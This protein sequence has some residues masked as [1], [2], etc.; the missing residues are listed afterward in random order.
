MLKIILIVLCIAAIG[1]G[2]YGIYHSHTLTVKNDAEMEKYR[3]GKISFDKN[4]GKTLV[5][6][7]S[8]SGNTKKLAELIKEK[9]KADIYEIE[10]DGN[11]YGGFLKTLIADYKQIKTKEYPKIKNELPDLSSYD[12]I[13]VGSPVW[14]YTVAPPVLS[15]LQSADLSGKTVV[16]F[17]SYGGN[18]GT[19]FEDFAANAKNAQTLKGFAVFNVLKESQDALENKVSDFLNN[20]EAKN[21]ALVSLDGNPTTGYSWEYRQSKDGVVRE[22]S[23]KYEPQKTSLA[24]SG[25][26]FTFVFEGISQ[27]ETELTFEYLRPWEKNVKPA[28]T[29]KYIFKVSPNKSVSFYEN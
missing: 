9:T 8:K 3:K 10:L 22:V 21:Y 4:F 27:G 14:G 5:V 24:G 6:Y 13:F 11:Y 16:P 15:F 7:Y 26:V 18:A 12:L 23:K 17:A 19:F 29:K 28:Q 1:A 25:G 2:G 20:L